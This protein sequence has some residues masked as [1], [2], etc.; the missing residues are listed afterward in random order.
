[1]K[2]PDRERGRQRLY[3]V[4]TPPGG[5]LLKSRD[6][7]SRLS[8]R[9]SLLSSSVSCL[10][11]TDTKASSRSR[12]V[13]GSASYHSAT[14]ASSTALRQVTSAPA[15]GGG[16]QP[17]RAPTR[18][19]VRRIRTE[20]A[21]EDGARPELCFQDEPVGNSFLRHS[22]EAVPRWFFSSRANTFWGAGGKTDRKLDLAR[23][24]DHPIATPPRPET[25]PDL[26]AHRI[27]PTPA[28][29]EVPT[30]FPSL[31][32]GEHI[33]WHSLPMEGDLEKYERW[34]GHKKGREGSFTRYVGPVVPGKYRSAGPIGR[35][36]K[37]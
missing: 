27:P 17:R 10:T 23:F 24:S 34:L 22:N 9:G 20:M 18:V 2:L 26:I 32:E 37:K 6:Q 35:P 15:S 21:A 16:V 7:H 19:R 33:R 36:R 14:A 25:E 8:S 5:E 12:G 3:H 1:M 11:R 30:M 28:K 29:P 4:T 31:Q 13:L